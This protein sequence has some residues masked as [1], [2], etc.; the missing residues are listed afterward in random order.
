MNILMISP[1]YPGPEVDKTS[2]K[3]VHYFTKEWV[4]QGENVQVISIPSY[5]PKVFYNVPQWVRPKLENKFNLV[6]PAN[7]NKAKES[8]IIDNVSVFRRPL[9]KF[10]PHGKISKTVLRKAQKDVVKYLNEIQFI[11]DII[12]G[13]W[14]KPSVFFIGGLKKVFGCPTVLV[15]H[16]TAFNLYQDSFDNIDMWS[17]RSESIRK[18]IETSFPKANIGFRCNSGIP[19]DFLTPQVKRDWTSVRRFSYIGTMIPRKY[20]DILIEALEELYG[21]NESFSLSMVGDGPL[22]NPLNNKVKGSNFGGRIH[23]LGRLSR[24]QII[25][26]LDNSDIFVM[27]SER[28][29]F[30]LVYLEAMARGC[31]VIASKGEGMEGIIENGINGFLCDAGSKEALIET[32]KV[33]EDLTVEQ[34]KNISANARKMAGKLSD[35]N[36]AKDYL[37]NL[38]NLVKDK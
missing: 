11:P 30:G 31:I 36:V 7:R 20:P 4:R 19:Q 9:F 8:Y 3:V 12:V 21:V 13:H 17:F 6:I 32:I 29:V 28:E 35:V 23:F 16:E 1:I 22:L 38:K 33:I 2:T 24:N 15:A 5:F 25:D 34:R 10:F 26:V 37:D 27:V 18:S 14:S